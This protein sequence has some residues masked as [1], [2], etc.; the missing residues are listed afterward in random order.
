M[1]TLLDAL[2]HIGAASMEGLWLP[3]FMWTTAALVFVVAFRWIVLSAHVQYGLS[4]A[5]FW[6]LPLGL[7]VAAFTEIALPIALPVPVPATLPTAPLPT[8]PQPLPAPEVPLFTLMHSL[9]LLV[10]LMIGWGTFRLL[11][12]GFDVWKLRRISSLPSQEIPQVILTHVCLWSQQLGLYRKPRLIFSDQ[13]TV[14]F[15]FGWSRPVVVLPHELALDLDA[16]RL[17]MLHE[18]THVRRRDF[19]WHLAEHVVSALLGWHPLVSHL[20][21]RLVH[22]REL[23]C[24]AEL[25]R[26]QA[27]NRKNYAALLLR[28]AE[29]PRPVPALALSMG[30]T[31]HHLKKRLLAMNKT[32]RM[33]APRW[34]ILTGASLLLL[35]ITTFV[36]CSD[37]VGPE[38]NASARQAIVEKAEPVADDVFVVVEEMPTLVGGLKVLQEQIQYPEI[39]KKA[40]I[41]G[42][43]I[44]Q[45][46]VDEEGNVTD[47]QVVKGLGGGISEEALRVLQAT[48][49]TPGRQNGENVKVKLSIP[50]S[51]RLDNDLPT[52]TPLIELS[53][54]FQDATSL[55]LV[56]RLNN[57][58]LT[59]EE[60]QAL[61]AELK[62]HV[63][64]LKAAP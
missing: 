51:F 27:L 53:P 24:D 14:P 52:T 46:I 9:G 5:L 61:Q 57:E 47:P 34:A 62:Q 30:D 29:T 10:V 60:R 1:Q 33:I 20:Q 6:S 3:M 17:V 42:R 11:Q 26:H 50:F 39:A 40:G 37:M 63:E 7:L 28:F 18:L 19:V 43:V 54:E 44:L 58:T 41:E 45:F 23:L 21:R 12:L 15:T 4:A 22:D 35:S 55:A 38:T 25:M 2:Q 31:H 16:L 59:V 56:N 32:T 36:A 49:F 64:T 8:L 13:A 48:K